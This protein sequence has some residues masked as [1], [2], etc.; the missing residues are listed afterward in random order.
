MVVPLFLHPRRYTILIFC[1]PCDFAARSLKGR[2]QKAF[3]D[4]HHFIAASVQ[5]I[6][7][8]VSMSENNSRQEADEPGNRR[9]RF[10]LWNAGVHARLSRTMALYGALLLW[11]IVVIDIAAPSGLLDRVERTISDG[12]L[13]SL[14]ALIV[15][16]ACIASI[17]GVVVVLLAPHRKQEMVSRRVCVTASVVMSLIL[18]ITCFIVLMCW[19]Q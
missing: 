11:C 19:I 17:A 9:L 8:R 12:G 10:R 15:V 14:L 3:N 16:S 13:G 1:F 6:P 4:R 5:A 18:V 2:A 7:R